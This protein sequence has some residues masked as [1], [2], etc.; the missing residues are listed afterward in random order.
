MMGSIQSRVAELK[1]QLLKLGY[2][3]FQL[4]NITK[5][6]IHPT[7]MDNMSQ[8]Q[9]EELI[10]VLERYARFAAKCRTGFGGKNDR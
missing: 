5:E 3:Q 6:A 2:H 7:E 9:G 10:E 4:D 8:Q 1:E